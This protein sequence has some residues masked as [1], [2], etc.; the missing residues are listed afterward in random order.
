MKK[1]LLT[2]T[3]LLWPM[4]LLAAQTDLKVV[5]SDFTG[6][7]ATN[8]T[9]YVQNLTTPTATSTA[10]VI[11][12]RITY[13]SDSSGIFYISN[14]TPNSLYSFSVQAPPSR[15]DFTV[16]IK[17]TD[18]GLINAHSNMV[19]FA[20]STSP[21]GAVAWSMASSD[22]R[23]QRV[24]QPLTNNPTFNP[25][26]FTVSAN[27]SVTN[28]ASGSFQSNNVFY[29]TASGGIQMKGSDGVLDFVLSQA[30]SL[31]FP[32][33]FSSPTL[34]ATNGAGAATIDGEGVDG[35][36][37]ASNFIARPNGR[38]TGNGV[39]I[40]NVTVSLGGVNFNTNWIASNAPA[41]P[42]GVATNL[43]DM[44]FVRSAGALTGLGAVSNN[45][46]VLG[47]I[48]NSSTQLF[49]TIV[50]GNGMRAGGLYSFIGNGIAQAGMGAY[51]FGAA[52]VDGQDCS[53]WGDLSFIG[54]GNDNTIGNNHPFLER[55]TSKF[56]AIVT[57]DTGEIHSR[58]SF[59]GSGF[60][61]GICAFGD[62]TTH[63][64]YSAIVGGRQNDINDGSQYAFIGGGN[65]NNSTGTNTVIGGGSGNNIS[66]NNSAISGG[67]NNTISTVSRGSFIGG[68]TNNTVTGVNGVIAGGGSNTISGAF[69]T[70]V[71]G[72]GNIISA[73]QGFVG[74]GANN[75]LSGQAGVIAGGNVNTNMGIGASVIVGGQ[76]NRIANGVQRSFIGGGEHN[77]ILD[78]SHMTIT[79]GLTNLINAFGGGAGAIVGGVLNDLEGDNSFILG[80]SQ[81]NVDNNNIMLGTVAKKGVQING[82]GDVTIP[83][84]LLVT[85]NGKF[86]NLTA[87]RLV[88]TDASKNLSS[89]TASGSTVLVAGDGSAINIG[90]GLLLSGGTLTGTG[91][92]GSLPGWGTNGNNAS[93]LDIL[94]T[95]NQMVF[96]M[97]AFSN[98]VAVF[99]TNNT[100]R[101]GRGQIIQTNAATD[102]SIFGGWSNVIQGASLS[103]TI[104]GGHENFIGA[105]S[106]AAFESV[107]LGGRG[108]TNWGFDSL[109]WGYGNTIGVSATSFVGGHGNAICDILGGIGSFIGSGTGNFIGTNAIANSIVGGQ[110]NNVSNGVTYT[111]L[112]G[113][114]QNSISGHSYGVIPGGFQNRVDGLFGY[115]A[116]NR[117][118]SMSQGAYVWGDSASADQ[119]DNGTDSY[120][121]R[122]AGGEY[123]TGGGV[124][125]LSWVSNNV[126]VNGGV[127]MA[128][129]SS[130]LFGGF[131]AGTNAPGNGR[132][133]DISN[134]AIGGTNLIQVD[135]PTVVKALE[136]G[137]NGSTHIAGP[138][139]ITGSSSNYSGGNLNVNGTINVTGATNSGLTASRAILTDANK[140][141]ISAA[142]SGAVP[143][144][145][146]GSAT[147][148]A[149]ITTLGITGYNME[150]WTAGSLASP[151][152][153][154]TYYIGGDPNLGTS[155]TYTEARLEVP[156]TGTVKYV[157]LKVRV[158]G[159]LAT[160]E[161]VVHNIRLNDTTDFATINTTYDAVTR[162]VHATGL[163]Q[164]VTAGDFIALKIA[165]PAWVTNP[166]TIRYRC[167]VY[168]E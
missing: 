34:I 60:F 146:D 163:S 52:I 35:S 67:A 128:L 94:G 3:L 90:G 29:S 19:A 148:A 147:T 53:T 73:S 24:G 95:T 102:A 6:S 156:K 31:A 99:D 152:D 159:T 40:S 28:I 143:M 89:A 109:I 86:F 38:F 22:L 121:I 33:G 71:G 160:S 8:R 127:F 106:I 113:G 74:G 136:I 20:T 81:T 150:L 97:V 100:I 79:G 133:T 120:T 144:N 91:S 96:R 15:T 149:Q 4:L 65:N 51:G 145:A 61:N 85:N 135:A 116:G 142:A 101:M 93:P 13:T 166:T 153:S 77:W 25:N 151:A 158:T 115:A 80:S 14:A 55:D 161:T 126:A 105:S 167:I 18:T 76:N 27:G 63:A 168:I 138:V 88:L 16:A 21:A 41:G 7:P 107:I 162:D 47:G 103:S 17:D 54:S 1:P 119:N 108:S 10:T 26:Q 154:T 137:T 112:G 110:F 48:A 139:V 165:T 117:A 87:S 111:F 36:I 57:G 131:Y 50:N 56:S 157:V 39:G 69:S 141:Q 9:V 140:G 122:A 66:D 129:S 42:R 44:L 75:N 12:N 155:T 46:M 5:L 132:G 83:H 78:G 125:T 45:S 104:V 49:A 59:I 114:Y 130:S 2:L 84:D 43:V 32:Q 30:N 82:S 134:G 123:L 64:D 23:Y 68:G 98:E 118:K 11:G 70:I 37:L 124:K 164:A 58:Y 92:G 62:E 72:G